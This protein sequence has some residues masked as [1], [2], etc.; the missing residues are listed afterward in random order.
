[1]ARINGELVPLDDS[2]PAVEPDEL[3]ALLDGML[4]AGNRAGEFAERHEIDLSRELDG[5]ARFRINA[6][7]QRGGVALVVR[8]IPHHIRTIEE[9]ALPPV[10]ATM[11]EEQRGI[12]LVT[13][14]TGSGKST[15]LAAMIHHINLTRAANIVTIEDPIEFVHDGP[16]L[17]DRP[18]RGRRRHALL[19][20]RAA[21]RASPGPGRD[22]DRRDARRGDRA[23]GDV[24]GRDRAP[25]ALD[26]PHA[27]RRPS[28]STACSSSSRPASTSRCARCSPARC[29]ASSRSDSC[30]RPTAGACRSARSCA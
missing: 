25:R 12:V 14:T 1:M 13:G 16:A 22:P 9:L 27:R 4:A 7:R 11:A 6:R 3:A 23:D 19:Q 5:V 30:R 28:R 15:T 17:A 20:G 18:A 10:I 8:A 21:T 2:A 29:A 26:D 24:G